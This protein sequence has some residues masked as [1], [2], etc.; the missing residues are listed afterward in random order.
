MPLACASPLNSRFQPSNPAGELP[1]CAASAAGT[2]ESSSAVAPIMA[3]AT[4]LPLVIA[5]SLPEMRDRPARAHDP[6]SAT[7]AQAQMG[8]IDAGN[9][10]DIERP[11]TVG[12]PS[13]AGN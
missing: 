4:V 13:P 6:T 1:H 7:I 12:R 9:A 10:F 2:R 11:F 3:V 5:R 8:P